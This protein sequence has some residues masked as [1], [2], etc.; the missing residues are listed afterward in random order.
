MIQ[1]LQWISNTLSPV[2]LLEK[3]CTGL[4]P[5]GG[6]GRDDISMQFASRDC[7]PRWIYTWVAGLVPLYWTN[8]QRTVDSSFFH[9]FAWQWFITTLIFRSEALLYQTLFVCHS[10]CLSVFLAFYTQKIISQL[11]HIFNNRQSSRHFFLICIS[12]I[13]SALL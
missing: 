1:F 2:K 9:Y 4:V 8:P 5:L 13:F 12:S 6:T 11:P 3:Q 10:F 7:R